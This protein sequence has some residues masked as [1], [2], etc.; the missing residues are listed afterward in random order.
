[1]IASHGLSTVGGGGGEEKSRLAN[2]MA[3]SRSHGTPEKK[4]VGLI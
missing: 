1:M 3:N 2:R 4:M